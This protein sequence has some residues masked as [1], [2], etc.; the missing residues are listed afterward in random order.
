MSGIS[1]KALSFGGLENKRKFNGGSELENKE[2]NDGSGLDLY[3]TDFR[4][5]DPQIGRWLQI[6]PKPDLSYSLYTAMNNNPILYNDINGDTAI[7]GLNKTAALG[8]GHTVLLFQDKSKSWFAYSQGANGG[9]GYDLVSGSNVP[10]GVFLK[11]LTPENNP[12]LKTGDLTANDVIDYA[13]N[14]TVGGYTLSDFATLNSDGKQDE[15][16]ATNAAQ[17]LVDHNNGDKKYNLYTNNCTDAIVDILNTNTGYKIDGNILIP[18]MD[19]PAIKAFI[20]IANMTPG[21]KAAYNK[22]QTETLKINQ[23]LVQEATIGKF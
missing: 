8:A 12:G 10:G 11:Q 7:V 22:K 13:K 17:S 23:K 18:K 14:N 6:D 5:L 20:T 16:I 15:T 1:S 3:S 9:G 21:Q 4:S 2:F 19:F